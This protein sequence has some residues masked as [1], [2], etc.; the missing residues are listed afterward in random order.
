MNIIYIGNFQPSH[1]TENHV[2]R[3]LEVLGHKI[4]RLQENLISFDEIE[5]R[6]PDNKF[7]LYTRTWNNI[8]GNSKEWLRIKTLPLV[9]FSLDIWIGL[10]RE[11]EVDS[12]LFFKSD[13]LFTADGGHQS[14]FTDRGIKHF[15]LQPGV[16]KDECYIALVDSAYAYDIIFVGSYRYHREYS[17][18]MHL[19]DFLKKI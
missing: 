9:G 2:A 15:W 5:E 4:L 1:S 12:Q 8:K 14:S 6:S 11:R 19:I 17:E 18:R 7:I 3:S 16:L 13:Y 10:Y